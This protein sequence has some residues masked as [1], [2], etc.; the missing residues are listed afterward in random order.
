MQ[1]DNLS[2]K[3]RNI[4]VAKFCDYSCYPSDEKTV[5]MPR[6]CDEVKKEEELV[7]YGECVIFSRAKKRS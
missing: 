3:K 1:V 2:N 6:V 5:F 7:W 4:C